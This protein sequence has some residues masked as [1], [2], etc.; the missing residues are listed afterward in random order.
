MVARQAAK[1]PAGAGAAKRRR[2]LRARLK[3]PGRAAHRGLRRLA[4]ALLRLTARGRPAPARAG[5]PVVRVLLQ[6]ANG[7]GGTIRTVLTTC[8]HLAEDHDVEI[9]SVLRWR[10]DPFFPVPD[11]VRVSVADDRLTPPRGPVA[12]WAR[13]VLRRL[14][15]VLTPLEDAAFRDMNLWTDLR[16]VRAV[17]SRPADVLVGTRPSLNLLLAELAPK[18]VITIGQDHR[19]LPGYRPALRAEI[20]RRYGR[21]TA[22]TTLTA[23]SRAGF[24]EALAGTPVRIVT[25]PNALTELRGG[26]SQR[27]EPVVLA[28]GRFVRAKGFDLLIK[29]YAPLAEKYPDWTLRIHGGGAREERLRKQIAEL[30]VG[31][32]IELLPRTDMGEALEH[33]SVYVLSSRMEGMPL[34]L[35][36]AMSK[37]LAV[38]AFDCPAGPAEMIEDGVDGLLVPA[39]DVD[40]LTSALDRVLS[41]RDLRDRLGKAA[42]A[43]TDA[44]RL[45]R[46][47]PLWSHLLDDL[48]HRP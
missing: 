42:P 8:A 2:K 3:D 44:Y 38:V 24:A 26:P 46:I 10:E 29:A 18:G 41:D 9:V 22:L 16:L 31:D 27:D 12:R 23:A 19:H 7:T 1:A 21:L 17:R 11:G 20:V 40:A 4:F 34:V 13:R 47:G 43:S 33:A 5:R 30:D 35:L 45:D 14:P 39:R 36:E 37:G 28:A 32:R 25:I 6:H 15:S 48:L